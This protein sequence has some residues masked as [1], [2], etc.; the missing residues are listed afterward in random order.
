MRSGLGAA[1]IS[2]VILSPRLS[3]GLGTDF[4]A[5]RGTYWGAHFWSTGEYVPSRLP[6]NPLYDVLAGGAYLAGGFAGANLISLISYFA[7]V[8]FFAKLAANRPNGSIT[9]VS[10]ACLP[11]LL[12]NSA[13]AMDYVPSLACVLASYALSLRSSWWGAGLLLGCA[14]AMR[15]SHVV[16]ML[17]IGLVA[18]RQAGSIAL[19]RLLGS[20][21]LLAAALYS[22]VWLRHGADMLAIPP[23][24][25][26]VRAYLLRLGYNLLN[27]FGPIA[28]FVL[29]AQAPQIWNGWKRIRADDALAMPRRAEALAVLAS[30]ALFVRHADES[31]Y[32]LAATPFLLLAV[33]PALTRAGSLWI[34]GALVS[35]AVVN[36]LTLAGTSG[37][38]RVEV[39]L[40]AGF[41]PQ[42]AS[43]RSD[44]ACVRRTVHCTDL[45]SKALVISS[46]APEFLALGNAGVSTLKPRAFKETGLHG[47]RVVVR[48]SDAVYVY[49]A[50][51]AQ[52]LAAQEDGYSV[53]FLAEGAPALA[54]YKYGFNPA[55]KGF[56]LVAGC[57]EGC[58]P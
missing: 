49:E 23:S 19:L 36:P 21:L 3:Q 11:L 41:L 33:G 56:P 55:S 58:R 7:C 9:T 18:W 2:A 10:F 25:L 24:V 39:G 5:W 53:L 6:G 42:D 22:P 20:S 47:P 1:L 12:V 8:A 28:T 31:A 27:V 32:L 54:R 17:P 43:R 14:M 50:S 26:D 15:L 48:G 4:D 13:S 35:F 46:L 16:F 34:L 52:I 44:L 40:A 57:R 37:E 45:P 29:V 30:G 51:P 38:R